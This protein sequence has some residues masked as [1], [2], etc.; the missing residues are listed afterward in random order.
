MKDYN[1]NL[2]VEVALELCVFVYTAN[3]TIHSAFKIEDIIMGLE[4]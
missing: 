2:T 3:V 4:P 1:A